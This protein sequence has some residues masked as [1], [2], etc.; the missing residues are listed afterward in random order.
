[1]K[2]FNT[3]RESPKSFGKHLLFWLIVGGFGYIVT[4]AIFFAVTKEI[5]NAIFLLVLVVCTSFICA[6]FGYLY[7]KQ[8]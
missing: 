7:D 4:G 1:M 8:K 5:H 3:F 6:L 2:F